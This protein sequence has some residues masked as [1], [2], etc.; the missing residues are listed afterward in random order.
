MNKFSKI[1]TSAL[2]AAVS[3][4]QTCA[5]ASELSEWAV[6]DYQM[7]NE[8]GL[9]SYSV[10]ANNMSA[11]ITREQFCELAVNL[12]RSLTNEQL[13]E[14]S[15]PAFS[16]TD[17]M[18]VSQAYLYGIVSGTSET[19]NTF[20]PKNQ[21]TRQEMAKMLVNTLNAAEISFAMA[22]NNDYSAL[23]GF[24]DASSTSDWAVGAVSTM[25]NYNFINGV[26][27]DRLEPLGQATREQAIASVNR[28]Y[29][30]FK[31]EDVVLSL[32]EITSISDGDE[33]EKSDITV[34]WSPVDGVSE[35]T[36]ILKDGNGSFITS[37]QASGSRSVVIPAS[38]LSANSDYVVIVGANM[39]SGVEIYSLPV[40]FKIKGLVNV[41]ISGNM[42]RVPNVD[43]EKAKSVLAEAEKYLGIMY[44]YGGTSPSTG[45]DCSGFTKYVFDKNGVSLNRTSRD[46]YAGN[47]VSVSKSDL[48]PGDLIFFGTG[49][50]VSHVGIYAGNGE[51]I[52]SPSTGKAIQYTSINSDYYTKRYIGAKRVL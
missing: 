42:S 9:I 46:Q 14:P 28:A 3:L 32:P 7:A 24:S 30:A 22:S 11:G 19:E 13:L 17:N 35:Y 44:K 47:G 26:T 48:Q 41:K 45:F 5:F 29:N 38:K 27:D 34:E 52:H 15:V 50:T 20:D 1:I 2:L 36:V 23:S 25:L 39:G 8:A 40:D 10:V 4:T 18:S 21:V 31:S 51:M 12:Y 49:G 37:I 6:S 33:L 16:D 43:D